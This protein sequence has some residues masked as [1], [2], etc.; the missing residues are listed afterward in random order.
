[1]RILEWSWKNYK[2][3]GAVVQNIKLN[4]DKGE[5]ILLIGKNGNGKS[6]VITALELGIYGQEQNKKG[7]RLAKR[8]FPN[9]INADMNINVKFETDQLLDITRT[10]SNLDAPLKTKL[11]IDKIPFD[12][13]NKIDGKIIEKIGFDYNTYKSFISMNVNNFKDFISLSPEEKRMLLD[14]LF[15]LEQINELNKILKQ[16]QKN[17]DIDYLSISKELTIYNNNVEQLQLAINK[18]LEKKKINNEYRIEEINSILKNHKSELDNMII[19]HNEL[20]E[21]I[22]EFNN[23]INK[24]ILKEQDI[25]RDIKEVNEK[26]NLY[27]LGKCPTCKTELTG[28]LNLL[29][30]YEDK[31]DKLEQVQDKILNKINLAKTELITYNNDFRNIQSKTQNI[32]NTVTTL[33]QEKKSLSV[34]DTIDMDDF[35]D[36]INNNKLKIQEKEKEYVEI[37][38]MKTIYSLLLP[39]WGENGIKRD[40]IE[41]I[42]TPLNEFINED[43]EFLKTRFKVN[44]DNNF[45]AHIYEFNKE[46]DTES[47]SSGEAKKINLIIML[48]YIKILRLKRD[49]NVLF[50]DEVFATI[51]IEGIDDI[52]VLFKKFAN[53][54][55]INVFLVHHSEL[56]EWFFD[57]IINTHKTTFSYL[58]TKVM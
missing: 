2:S 51:D 40:L 16:L 54:R 7:T 34:E 30:D 43:L 56:K 35:N 58:E 12:K 3:Y 27:K 48:A 6:S 18:S 37:E 42:L 8:N 55:D 10:M 24:L 4:Q 33:K 22:N 52:L 21:I 53:E 41:S 20:E 36:N 23:G 17:N 26:I 46:I 29:P 39:I 19:E 25:R 31:L 5:L 13:A 15:N 32:I 45:D 11:V 50:L 9:R 57:K 47:L 28:E 38:K 1:M 14:K 49:I 44:L